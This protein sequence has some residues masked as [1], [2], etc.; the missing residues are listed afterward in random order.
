MQ[1]G[2]SYLVPM[3]RLDEAVVAMRRA[4]ELDPVSALLQR[5]LGFVYFVARQYERAIE[6]FRN[7]LELDPQFPMA[8]LFLGL[9]YIESARLDEGIRALETAADLEGRSPSVLGNLGA[10]YA[11]AGRISEARKFLDLLQDLAQKAYVPPYSFARI[12]LALGETDKGFDWLE[13]AVDEQDYKATLLLVGPLSD[14]L[15]SHP[16]YRALLRKMNLEP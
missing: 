3:R 1:Y 7:A 16:R 11:R 9:I 5:N 15:R 13:K 14:P 4:L 2:G 6:Q 10:A 8:H 12:H